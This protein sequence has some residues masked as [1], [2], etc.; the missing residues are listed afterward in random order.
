MSRQL[1]K[2]RTCVSESLEKSNTSSDSRRRMAI[3]FSHSVSLVLRGKRCIDARFETH[4]RESAL[5]VAAGRPP[6]PQWRLTCPAG[7]KHTLFPAAATLGRQRMRWCMRQAGREGGQRHQAGCRSPQ[8]PSPR[9]SSLGGAHNVWDEGGPL[10]RP[11]L[12][13]DVHQHLHSGGIQV[14]HSAHS[15][16]QS[17]I[18]SSISTHTQLEQCHPLSRIGP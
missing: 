12:L 4:I 5:S 11:V 17:S 15:A 6:V 9:S 10:V 16:K 13:Q 8:L 3:E 14:S 2:A 18:N 7:Q 1:G